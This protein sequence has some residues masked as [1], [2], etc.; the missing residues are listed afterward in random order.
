MTG[1]PGVRASSDECQ[2]DSISQ[3]WAA[4]RA[5]AIRIARGS[6]SD[7]AFARA[8]PRRRRGSS[9][10]SDPPFAETHRD[11]GY[12]KAY[13][14]GIREN[15]G[16]YSHAAAWLGIAFAMQG[17]G[18]RAKAVFDRLN[19]ILHSDS[20]EK[21]ARYLVE[22]YVVPPISAG[23]A[24]HL[25]RG[26]WSWYTGAA[27][28]TWRLGVEHILGIRLIDGQIELAPCL[29]RG[30]EGFKATIRGKG[31][32]RLSVDRGREP[33]LI[34]DGRTRSSVREPIDF[35]GDGRETHVVLKVASADEPSRALSGLV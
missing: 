14:P 16:Q 26:G 29:P 22:P 7:A 27:A 30:W 24:P 21:A 6:R 20:E 5:E 31:T 15:G 35:P 4:S 2:I 34:I 18:D 23:V 9:A 1:T 11:P 10:C 8:C 25:G 19:P 12:I 33:A 32:I 3:S 17:D 13:P 28:W